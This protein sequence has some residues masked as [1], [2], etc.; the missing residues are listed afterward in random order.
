MTE[1]TQHAT[2]G[3]LLQLG[4]TAQHIQLHRA[5]H[6]Q[7]PLHALHRLPAAPTQ[8]CNT[9]RCQWASPRLLQGYASTQ[10]PRWQCAKDW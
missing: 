9:T 3:M 6:A 7:C 10:T 2:A 5:P 8:L 1:R 4:R